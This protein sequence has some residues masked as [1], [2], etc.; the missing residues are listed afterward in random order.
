MGEDK[1][2]TVNQKRGRRP[3]QQ[4]MKPKTEDAAC[5][6]AA[7]DKYAPGLGL[8]QRSASFMLGIGESGYLSQL[9]Q[10]HSRWSTEW[11]MKFSLLLKVLPQHIWPKWEYAAITSGDI[12]GVQYRI[13]LYVRNLTP[14]RVSEVE[15]FCHKKIMEQAAEAKI[16]Q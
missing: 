3:K 14:E 13:L 16:S 15:Q 2:L 8:T 9:L 11:K 12:D 1:G 10:G 4:P 5:A 6:R 7:W